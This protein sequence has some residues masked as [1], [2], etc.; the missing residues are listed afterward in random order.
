MDDLITSIRFDLE[1]AGVQGISHYTKKLRDNSN[2]D[3]FQHLLFEGRAAL[4]FVEVGFHVILQEAPDLALKFNGEQIYA[5]VKHF[6][7][8]EQDKVD[9]KKMSEPGDLLVPYGDTVQ[10]EGKPAWQQVYDEAKKKAKKYKEHA[11]YILVIESSSPNCIEESDIKT[12]VDMIDDDVS[13]S[14]C[15]ELGKLN[16]ILLVSLNSYSLRHMRNAYFYPT[17]KPDV[18]LTLVLISLLNKIRSG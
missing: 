18:S 15:R 11:P 14:R 10:S 4:M 5:E 17:N 2:S 1:K 6:K 16:G 9:D 12:A 7:L 3:V 8:K 13:S